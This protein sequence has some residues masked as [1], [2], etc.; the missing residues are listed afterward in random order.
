MVRISTIA[1]VKTPMSLKALQRDEEVTD[2]EVMQGYAC[3]PILGMFRKHP[4][5]IINLIF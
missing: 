1:K 5:C 3:V 2:I 4:N